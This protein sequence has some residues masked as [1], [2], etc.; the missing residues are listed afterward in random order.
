MPVRMISVIKTNVCRRRKAKIPFGRWYIPRYIVF[1]ADVIVV[2][3]LEQKQEDCVQWNPDFLG[4]PYRA[5]T[6]SFL[7]VHN[8]TVGNVTERSVMY[9]LVI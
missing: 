7:L 2:P 1:V 3:H 4:I 9:L 8:R 5:P 6:S